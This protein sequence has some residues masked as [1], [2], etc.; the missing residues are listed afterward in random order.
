MAAAK[1]WAQ[2]RLGAFEP[3]LR[4][5]V[6]HLLAVRADRAAHRGLVAH[7]LG[8]E[9][10]REPGGGGSGHL[11]RDRP[12]LGDPLRETTGQDPDIVVAE[13]AKHPP[14]PACGHAP[15]GA[16]VGNDPVL[17]ANTE[18]AHMRRE[19]L[20]RRQHMW[21]RALAVRDLVDV[22]EGCA[23]NVVLFVI[24]ACGRRDAR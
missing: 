16:V 24:L 3:A 9:P 2:L 6:D 22:E 14:D 13:N 8:T 7:Q 18:P 12:T 4:T 19:L 1:A 17:A 20:R 15:A 21:Q 5:G 23:G 11:H 10:R